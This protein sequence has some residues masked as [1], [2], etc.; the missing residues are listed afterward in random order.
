MSQAKVR[1]V[2]FFNAQPVVGETLGLHF[3]EPRYRLLV[4]RA[5]VRDHEFVFLPNFADYQASHGDIGYI[6]TIVGHRAMP[7]ANPSELPRADVQLKFEQRCVILFHWIE[8]NSGGL[9]ECLCAPIDSMLPA[10]EEVWPRVAVEPLQAALQ[11]AHAADTRIFPSAPH[12]HPE[13]PHYLLHVHSHSQ[14]EETLASIEADVPGARGLIYPVVTPPIQRTVSVASMIRRLASLWLR[15]SPLATSTAPLASSPP[16]DAAASTAAST[17]AGVATIDQP[18]DD[19]ED[20]SPA[21]PASPASPVSPAS[22]LPAAKGTSTLHSDDEK[23]AAAFRKLSL[24]ELRARLYDLRI[25]LSASCLEKEDLVSLLTSG[26]RRERIGAAAASAAEVVSAAMV[27]MAIPVACGCP[28]AG[29]TIERC[30][31][32][33]QPDGERLQL[34]RPDS[35]WGSQHDFLIDDHSTPN[36]VGQVCVAVYDWERRTLGFGGRARGAGR[37]AGRA[38]HGGR[39][40]SEPAGERLEAS[41]RELEWASEVYIPTHE[42]NDAAAALSH[43]CVLHLSA[44]RLDSFAACMLT[45]NLARVWHADADAAV[46]ELA[47]RLHWPRVRLLFIGHRE[48]GEEPALDVSDVAGMGADAGGRGEGA[49]PA[50]VA[51]GGSLFSLLDRELLWLIAENLVSAEAAA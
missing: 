19:E 34:S 31:F 42:E 35:L 8:S 45:P 3:F 17:A 12:Q 14:A 6:V 51:R 32:A 15:L 2:F 13:L 50:V 43:A 29:L 18:D 38:S 28:S 11:A 7:G 30:S 37:D 36:N 41:R 21:S 23:A 47:R 49:M 48:V 46:I 25:S 16:E 20:E 33:R 10:L 27:G 22:A 4:Q 1:S 5:L 26:A 44:S 24:K 39:G 40:P 9:S